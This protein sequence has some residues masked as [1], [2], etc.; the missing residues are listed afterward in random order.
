MTSNSEN[1]D[2]IIVGSGIAGL[3]CAIESAKNG[4]RVAVLSKESNLSECNT[5][6]AQGGIVAGSPFDNIELLEKDILV[7]GNYANNR[8]AVSI[9]A[10]EGAQAVNDILV[11][12]A[13][14][15]FCKKEDGTYDLTREAAH[16]VRRIYH[17]K[18]RTGESIESHLLDYV[19]TQT[20]IAL[21]PSCTAVDIITNTH[22]SKNP[23]EKYRETRSL[24]LYVYNENTQEVIPFFA[25][26]TVLASGGVGNLFLHTSNP[27]GAVGD[28][29]AMAHRAGAEIIN[30]EY[31]QFHPTVLFHRDVKRFLISEALR[32]EGARLMNKA[33][34]YFMDRYQPLLKDLAPRDQ[35]ARAIYM[36]MEASDSSYVFLDTKSLKVDPQDRF[37][38][39]FERCLSAG[40][41][42]RK[43]PIPVVP[44]AHYFCGG[45][46][47]NMH[48]QTNIPGLYAVGET[49]CSGIH[50]ANR[51]ASISLLEALVFGKRAGLA[52]TK[53]SNKNTSELEQSIPDWVFPKEEDS[54]DPILMAHDL[55][56]VQM[57]MWDYAGIIRT[58]KRLKRALADLNYLNHR[59][60]SFYREARISRK[61]LELRNAVLTAELIT[62]AA[63]ANPESKGCHYLR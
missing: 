40:I 61:L 18:D 5:N 41:D 62:E 46:K 56:N 19:K 14:V 51:L 4:A 31:V 21:F 10:K 2:V 38:A 16:S 45:V 50:G 28:G 3:S 23:E 9:V 13:Q 57:T 29:I 1:F 63:L 49:S 60:D 34:E 48:G 24:G 44:A 52:A 37:P 47:T 22:H 58:R 55:L 7:A 12:L 17:V 20:N 59:I 11:K 25:P 26:A 8:E 30:A 27:V 53:E 32:G 43:D 35:V 33:G 42:I 6:Y 15:P 54:I 39:I 36:E